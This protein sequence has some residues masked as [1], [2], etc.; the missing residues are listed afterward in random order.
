M[1]GGYSSVKNRAFANNNIQ[2]NIRRRYVE[3]ALSDQEGFAEIQNDQGESAVVFYAPFGYTRLNWAVL[4]EG[5]A[6]R[7]QTSTQSLRDNL[8]TGLILSFIMV[9]LVAFIFARRIAL[10]IGQ[11]SQ[12]MQSVAKGDLDIHIDKFN[13]RDE[14]GD[15]ARAIEIFKHTEQQR[16][17][18]ETARTRDQSAL[19]ESETRLRTL[20]EYAPDAIVVFNL[21]SERL[22]EAN[23]NAEQLFGLTNTELMEVAIDSLYPD[24]QPD[25]R[26]SDLNFRKHLHAAN[27]GKPANFQWQVKNAAGHEFPCEIRLVSIPSEQARLVRASLL[28]ISVDSGQKIL[29]E[30]NTR[31]TRTQLRLKSIFE[32]VADGII[33][34]NASGIVETFNPAAEDIFGR[35]SPE[36]IGKKL[37]FHPPDTTESYNNY[38]SSFIPSDR[39]QSW[40][41]TIMSRAFISR[42][43]LSHFQLI[44]PYGN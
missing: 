22:I 36:A 21:D 43:I 30:T 17:H 4:A 29:Q 32:A 5:G 37:H 27:D 15:M 7:F 39:G 34:V 14:V 26:E 33:L 41:K 23:S 1:R 44:F 18:L 24:K 31:L 11:L 20:F 3:K 38:L 40:V 12:A 16:K 6:D 2:D 8:L 42:V 10:P 9:G 25:G 19:R 35:T 28:D 13:R